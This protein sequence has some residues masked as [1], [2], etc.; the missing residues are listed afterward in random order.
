M[1]KRLKSDLAQDI[2]RLQKLQAI[3]NVVK[4][5]GRQSVH[6]TEDQLLISKDVLGPKLY[7]DGNL[8]FDETSHAMSR[9]T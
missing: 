4:Q 3:D 6:R 8:S 2:L 7:D 9:R 5:F 1:A